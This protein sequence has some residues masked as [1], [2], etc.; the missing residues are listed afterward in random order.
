MSCLPNRWPL[1]RDAGEDVTIRVAEVV[2]NKARSTRYLETAEPYIDGKRVTMAE[3][4]ICP[5][6][7]K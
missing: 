3:L 6:C 7:T 1:L 2:E 5:E 4:V